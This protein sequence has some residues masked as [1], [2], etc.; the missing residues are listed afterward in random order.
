MV[1]GQYHDD[2]TLA[3]GQRSDLAI[4]SQQGPATPDHVIRTKRLPQL[5]RNVE[6]YANQY[7]EY[8]QRNDPQ[9]EEAKTML[10]PAPRIILDPE[11]GMLTLGTSAKSAAIAGD[12]YHHTMEIIQRATGLGGY[13]ALPESDI[14]AVEYWDLEQA[15]LKK[16]GKAPTF[17]GEVALVTGGASGIGKATVDQLLNQGAAVIALDIQPKICDLYDRP[18]FIGIQCDLTDD[19]AFKEA[20]EKGIAQFGGLDLLVLNA[21]IFPVARA[22]AELSTLEW[23]RILNINLDANLSLLRECYPLLKLAPRGGR[24]VVIGSKNVAAP[25]PGLA[26][27]SAS[28]AA[29]NQ[30]MRVATLEWAKD[31]IRLNTIHPNGV[32][33][34]GFWTE[35]VLQ[36]RAKHYGLTVE[37]YKANNLLKVEITSQDVAALVIAMASPLFAKVT[38]AQ[39]P[40]DGGNERVI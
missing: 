10:D 27:Y 12:I 8:F 4:I 1:M 19:G 3:F 28:K 6:N 31:N 30:L 14:F 33:D 24:V 9:G 36:T 7:R 15:K 35:E 17:A 29:L 26:A 11:L 32:F 22:I 18:D 40:L 39:L 20:L 25:G 2:A 16:A 13:Q 23:Q 37:E 34:T 21:G 5:G 38:G